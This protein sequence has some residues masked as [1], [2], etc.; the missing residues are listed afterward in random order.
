MEKISADGN[1][2][3]GTSFA[4]NLSNVTVLR[5][6]IF[7]V[8]ASSLVEGFLFAA[9]VKEEGGD[10]EASGE[11]EEGSCAAGLSEL[12]LGEPFE[13]DGLATVV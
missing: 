1:S 10:E 7:F 9:V 3:L 5:E 13:S 2:G 11:V 8:R 4:D 6:F 12:F